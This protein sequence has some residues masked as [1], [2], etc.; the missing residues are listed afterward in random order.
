ML[1]SKT[2]PTH[3]L[4]L[5]AHASI[6]LVIFCRCNDVIFVPIFNCPQWISKFLFPVAVYL[7]LL[8][9][10]VSTLSILVIVA[11]CRTPILEGGVS[12]VLPKP[13]LG[14]QFAK[15]ISRP[16]LYDTARQ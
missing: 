4:S 14:Q 3:P 10:F 1:E 9:Q 8:G 2:T 5:V 7:S 15:P 6:Q 12:R 13:A 16:G 11:E